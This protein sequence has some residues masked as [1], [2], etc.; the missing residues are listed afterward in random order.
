[1]RHFVVDAL[2]RRTVH[3]LVVGCGG[4]GSAFVAGLPYLHQAM[5]V[6][7]HPGGLNVSLMDGDAVSSTNCIRQPFSLHEIGLNKAV[8]LTTRVNLF[9]GLRW[10]AIPEHFA[11]QQDLPR[12]D[13][14]VGCVD[15]RRARASIH[16]WVEDR[17]RGVHYWLDL[18]NNANSGQFILGQPL[19]AANPRKAARLRTC[20]EL[21]PEIIDPAQD[22]NDGPSCSAAEALERQEPFLNSTLA[23]HAL[24]LL[25]RL[26]LHGSISHHG[27]FVNMECGTTGAAPIDSRTW[28]A[29]RRRRPHMRVPD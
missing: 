8:V 5:L 9:F 27:G 18:G 24:A 1:M 22:A 15:T 16:G 2:L 3:V 14:L 29:L 4:N 12:A 10:S 13:I 6:R 20:A 26:F 17:R 19:N 25:A 21:F 7:G 28:R 11:G 23:N